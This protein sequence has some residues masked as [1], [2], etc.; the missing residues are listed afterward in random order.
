[1]SAFATTPTTTTT[2]PVWEAG[3]IMVTDGLS[4]SEMNGL[5]CELEAKKVDATGNVRW[6]CLILAY[7]SG[8]EEHLSIKPVNLIDAPAPS[9]ESSEYVKRLVEE[10]DKLVAESDFAQAQEKVMEALT[11]VPQSGMLHQLMGDTC[12]RMQQPAAS[13]GKHMRRS[14]ANSNGTVPGKKIMKGMH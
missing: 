6:Q 12:R 1:M 2:T 5:L 4:K 3:R 11:H 8:A 13:F 14:V 7:R 10:H 9:E